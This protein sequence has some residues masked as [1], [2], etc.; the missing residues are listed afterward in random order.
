MEHQASALL[1]V[2][3]SLDALMTY[4]FLW[5]EDLNVYVVAFN[6]GVRD[7]I[8]CIKGYYCSKMETVQKKHKKDDEAAATKDYDEHFIEQN[9]SVFVYWKLFY[10]SKSMVVTCLDEVNFQVVFTGPQL[11]IDYVRK[12]IQEL[13]ANEKKI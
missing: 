5:S 12:Q 8:F 1:P 7:F 6:R 10:E 9:R 2:L 13:I 11:S 4:V 3:I